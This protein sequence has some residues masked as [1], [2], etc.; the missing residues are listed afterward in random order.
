MCMQCVVDAEVLVRDVVPGYQLM[1]SR[2]GSETW[3]QGDEAWPKDFL[4]LVQ[5]NDPMFVIPPIPDPNTDEFFS[6]AA[7][8]NQ[9]QGFGLNEG[10]DL[11]EASRQAGYRGR[12]TDGF[13]P[14]WLFKLIYQKLNP[15]WKEIEDEAEPA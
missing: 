14:H 9:E 4:G 13:L 1:R 15:E 3:P 7:K 10:W 11:V 12:E 2:G 5:C 6:F 8:F